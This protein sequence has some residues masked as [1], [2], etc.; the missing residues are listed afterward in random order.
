MTA[1]ISCAN[2]YTSKKQPARWPAHLSLAML[3]RETH[4]AV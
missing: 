2:I 1:G 4:A 3:L